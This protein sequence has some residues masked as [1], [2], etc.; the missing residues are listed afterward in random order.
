[1]L[2]RRI[3]KS[4]EKQTVPFSQ[5]ISPIRDIE[6]GQQ[7]IVILPRD[8]I[9]FF[10]VCLVALGMRPVEEVVEIIMEVSNPSKEKVVVSVVLRIFLWQ[11]FQSGLE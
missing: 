3:T 2:R 6:P 11:Q 1:M 5:D 7:L 4:R 9:Q 10:D 8:A